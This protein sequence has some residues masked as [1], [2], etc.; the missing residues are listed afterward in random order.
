MSV[1]TIIID[2]PLDAPDAPE[3]REHEGDANDRPGKQ[4]WIDF[5]VPLF[6]LARI[7]ATD[8][9]GVVT[10]D[11]LGYFSR[12][13]SEPFG[14]GLVVQGYR[15]IAQ[16]LW[17]VLTD[18][19]GDIAGWDRV[20]GVAI[21]QRSILIVGMVLVWWALRGWAI[22]VLLIVTTPVYVVH[23]DF[24]L[25]EGFL[26]PWCLVAAGLAA[27]VA[28]KSEFTRRYPLAVA[29][30][31]GAMAFLTATIKLQ[32]TSLLCLTC[33]VAWILF[34]ENLLSRRASIAV[35]LIP[36][37]L[38]ASLALA[39]SFE[40]KS[41][42]GVFEPVSER[43]RAE[44]YGAW[45]ATFVADSENRADES[46]AEFFDEGN[47]YTFLKGLE[48]SEPDYTVR[49]EAVHERIDLMFEAAGTSP[50]RERVKS[51]L[52]G[53]RAGRTDDI[54]GI[55]NRA[56]DA[57]PSD[58][59]GRL[60]LN[61]VGGAGGVQAVLD[62]VNESQPSG[63]LSTSVMFGRFG[64]LYEDYRPLKAAF[65]LA[66]IILLA[67]S[68]L[69][70]GPHRPTSLAALGVIGSVSAALGSAYIDNARY[71]LGPMTIVLVL[72]S[73]ALRSVVN[74]TRKSV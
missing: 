57:T 71:L 44:W 17:I 22:P 4:R 38:A 8:I 58:Q 30:T 25:P 60:T 49:V 50:T 72:A 14:E 59:T 5:I 74:T 53:L 45:Q 33:A 39:Q 9:A 43:A 27:N 56:L 21:M 55:V 70:P 15:Q 64:R 1:G 61:N 32:Y 42:L 41:E 29:A 62:T 11:S 73:V 69:I 13:A 6:F 18:T 67:A 66:G 52:G 20:F 23:A 34:K 68:L 24:V 31:S 40:N 63:V 54:G 48:G 26:I 3:L 65:S 7:L 36:L 35:I 51:F 19:I 12:A 47:L 10:N 37:S 16:P 46:Q 2:D 28:T